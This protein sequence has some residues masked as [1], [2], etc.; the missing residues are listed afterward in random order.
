MDNLIKGRTN[1]STLYL[2]FIVMKIKE[3]RI[4]ICNHTGKEIV[5]EYNPEFANIEDNGWL[6]LHKD[7]PDEDEESVKQFRNSE[8]EIE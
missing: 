4:A 5:Q 1:N 3:K 2:I 8:L 6:C 7:T